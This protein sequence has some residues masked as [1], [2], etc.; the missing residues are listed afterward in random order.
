MTDP[1]YWASELS[2][3]AASADR[4]FPESSTP[5]SVPSELIR[6]SRLALIGEMVACFAH[7]VSNPLMVLEGNLRL[8]TEKTSDDDGNRESVQAAVEAAERIG[9]MATRMLEFNRQT[10]SSDQP[11][12]LSEAINDAYRFVR[13]YLEMRGVSFEFDSPS[14]VT[15]ISADRNLIIQALT[16]LF[17][18]AADA[19]VGCSQRRLRVFVRSQDDHLQIDVEDTGE[20]IPGPDLER[21]FEPFFTTKGVLGTGLGLYITRRIVMEE[22][23]GAITAQNGPHT[24]TFTVTL[25]LKT[26]VSGR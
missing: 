12:E 10:P 16:N 15:P 13:P 3:L 24:T 9:K 20:G 22:L 7:E 17:Q 4:D 5:P 26:T 25:P 23:K 18:N 14:H 21:V 19:M 6:F 11:F 8:I 2:E 1:Q